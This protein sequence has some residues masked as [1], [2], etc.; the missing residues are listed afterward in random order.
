[1]NLSQ[2]KL[3]GMCTTFVGLSACVSLSDLQYSAEPIEAWIVDG[4]TGKP[5][6]GAIVVAH[7]QLTR[8]SLGGGEAPVGSMMVMETVTDVDGRFTFPGWGPLPNQTE[9]RL[10][11]RDPTM[12]AF[13][14]N[15]DVVE[16]R[17]NTWE[18]K[19]S[20]RKSDW[21]G[22]K[23]AVRPFDGNQKGYA[24]RLTVWS[25]SIDSNLKWGRNC[26]FRKTP[27]LADALDREDARL[28]AFGFVGGFSFASFPP[29]H[30]AK[31]G[32]VRE[33]RTVQ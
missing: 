27:L 5:L 31:C 17:N 33:G 9:G 11:N 25:H 29:Q 8:G 15:Y 13:K 30:L 4:A 16:L 14:S 19:P 3:L 21:N 24:D 7:W 2:L 10:T 18:N 6:E 28:R 32:I 22:K 26:N 12:Y 1:M 20:R 23:I